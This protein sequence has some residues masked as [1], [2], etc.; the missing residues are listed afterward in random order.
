MI[1]RIILF[2]LLFSIT[3]CI[4]YKDLILFRNNEVPLPDLAPI[5][6]PKN[7]DLVIQPDDALSIT[8]SSLDPQLAVPFNLVDTRSMGYV[9]PGAQLVSFLVDSKGNIDYPV[10]G[11]INVSNKTIPQLR[12]TLVVKLQPY[13]KDPSINI[14]RVN[15]RVSVLG[16]VTRPGTFNISSERIALLEAIGM[17]GD[18][19][20]HSDRQRVLV[21]RESDGKTTFGKIDLQSPDFFN[22]PYYF[23]RQNDVVYI[24]PKKNKRGSVNDPASKYITWGAAGLSAISTIATIIALLRK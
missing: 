12:D 11:K 20:P 5:N 15:F 10:L 7:I 13:I 22:S 14:R 24:D 1:Y 16:E 21:V 19:T 8:V 18:M 9:Q 2:S 6:T 23:L 3:S 17:A 4:P